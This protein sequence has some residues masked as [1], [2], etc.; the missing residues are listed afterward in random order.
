MRAGVAAKASAGS[1]FDG[2]GVHI[3]SPDADSSMG[4]LGWLAGM[5]ISGAE[6]R[7]NRYFQP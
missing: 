2:M 1:E 3:A 5:E 6:S 4:R 7:K